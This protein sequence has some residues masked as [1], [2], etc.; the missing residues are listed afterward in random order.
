MRRQSVDDAGSDSGIAS[1]D[2]NDFAA[3]VGYVAGRVE[4]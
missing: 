1:C 4:G 3:E 2:E